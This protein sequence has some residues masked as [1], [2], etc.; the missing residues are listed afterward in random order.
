MHIHST[1]QTKILHHIN[2]QLDRVDRSKSNHIE[3]V[4]QQLK[5]AHQSGLVYKYVN[6][7]LYKSYCWAQVS[8]V[9]RERSQ[10]ATP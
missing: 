5:L 4:P 3:V 10:T 1:Y 8:F 2:F 6:N 7:R 9:Q